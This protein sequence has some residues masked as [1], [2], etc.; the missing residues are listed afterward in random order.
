M[1][2]KGIFGL[3]K[4]TASEWSEDKCSRLAAAL[5]YYTIF[6]LA[7]LLIIAIA[8][9]GA[10]FGEEAARGQIVTQIQGMVGQTGAEAIQGMIQTT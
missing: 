4:T 3:L 2:A 1:K 8:V 7:P 6:S 5:A 9:A 10:V